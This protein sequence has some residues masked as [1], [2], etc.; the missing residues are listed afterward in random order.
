MDLSSAFVKFDASLSLI[1]DRSCVVYTCCWS[2]FCI[3]HSET[4]HVIRRDRIVNNISSTTVKE[5][6][7]H[8]TITPSAKLKKLASHETK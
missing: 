1:V 7:I 2:L 8:I 4:S 3:H 5:R 6:F